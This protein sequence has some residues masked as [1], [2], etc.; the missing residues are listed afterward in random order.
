M[1][2]FYSSF[3][4]KYNPIVFKYNC[5]QIHSKYIP[6]VF[7]YIPNTLQTALP[8]IVLQSNTIHC[9]TTALAPRLPVAFGY[10]EPGSNCITIKYIRIVLQSHNQDDSNCITIKYNWL[11]RSCIRIKYRPIVLH[12]NTIELI[13]VVLQ[14]ITNKKIEIGLTGSK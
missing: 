11:G 2:F 14:I 5:I 6:F 4:S 7:E 8:A 13:A 3:I 12:L 9:N 10:R 1:G